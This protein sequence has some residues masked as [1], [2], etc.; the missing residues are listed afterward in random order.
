MIAVAGDGLIW[1]KR[2]PVLTAHPVARLTQVKPTIA[3]GP[4]SGRI[5][6]ANTMVAGLYGT[7][8]GPQTFLKA[9]LLWTV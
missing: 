4:Y 8:C 7:R 9:Q 2:Q 5:P 3:S 6:E 1:R